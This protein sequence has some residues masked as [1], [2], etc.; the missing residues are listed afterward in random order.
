MQDDPT[1]P[2]FRT[3]KLL[4]EYDGTRYHGWQKQPRLST[5]QGILEEAVSRITGEATQVVGAGRTD[6]GVHALGQAA[7]FKTRRILQESA[8][9]R[10]LN[11]LLPK[12]IVVFQAEYVPNDFHARYSAVSKIYEYRILNQ[13]LPSA[14]LKDTAWHIP[15]PDPLHL[16][17]MREAAGTLLGTHDFSSFRAA[18]CGA[19]N[20][21]RTL[22]R[23]DIIRGSPLITLTFEAEAFLHHMV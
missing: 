20:P 10:A 15:H 17:L 7:H 12:D 3:V 21:I 9:V 8:W 14:F 23:L 5:V 18:E 11:S 4:L 22:Q 1:D 13:P 6:A 19:K 16:E 2:P